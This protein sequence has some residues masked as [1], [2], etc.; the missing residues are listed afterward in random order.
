MSASGALLWS[1]G[2]ISGNVRCNGGSISGSGGYPMYLTGGTLINVGVLTLG[3]GTPM[4]TGSGSVISNLGTFNVVMDVG[5]VASGSGPRTIDNAGLFSKTGGAGT[6]GFVESFNNTGTV[7]ADSGTL[8]LQGG[9][10]NSGINTATGTATLTF[11]GGTHTLDVSSR[12]TGDGTVGCSGGAVNFSGTC[13]MT[14]TNL[15]NGG[16][17][18]FSN[19]APASVGVVRVSFGHLGGQ[20]VGE[21]ERGIALELRDD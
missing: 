4:Y 11:G 21:C 7:E 12:I 9:G 18:N 20:R 2:T 5:T 14:G 15:V 17:M 19:G 6:S 3:G 13:A 1:Y 10:S 8:S 16:T